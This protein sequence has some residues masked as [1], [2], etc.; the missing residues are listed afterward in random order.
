MVSCTI[1]NC[2]KNSV[3]LHSHKCFLF[4]VENNRNTFIVIQ[5]V[6][7][8]YKGIDNYVVVPDVWLIMR[9]PINKRVFVSYPSKEDPSVTRDRAKRLEGY[10]DEWRFYAAEIKYVSG[11]N[12]TLYR[13]TLKPYSKFE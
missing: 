4:Q 5:F 9:R 11:E 7:L 13:L 6:Q 3:S 8:P 2:N 12:L 10:C 1:N